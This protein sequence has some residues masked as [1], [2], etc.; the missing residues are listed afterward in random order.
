MTFSIIHPSRSRPQK[1]FETI[2]KWILKAG[3]DDFEIIVSLDEDD[4][5]LPRY[6]SV[7]QNLHVTFQ[8]GK[9]K[10]AVEAINRAAR[11]AQGTIF[12]VVSDDTDCCVRWGSRLLKYTAGKTDFVL[13]TRDG[14]QPTMITMPILDRVYYQRDGYIY[15][16][17]FTHCWSDRY[18]T[19]VAHKRKRV[20]T[21]NITF[22]HLHYSIL[23]KKPDAQYQR[24]DATFNEGKLIYKRLMA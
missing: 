21:K 23:K 7:Y 9:N 4:T 5:E 24:T 10:G 12:I 13:K 11:V 2:Q 20:I 3:M 15:H 16:P 6:W 22:R 1:S 17:D 8:I 14:I 19:E 18:F